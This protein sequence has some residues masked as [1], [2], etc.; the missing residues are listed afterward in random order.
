MKEHLHIL[1]H[2]IGVDKYGRGQEYRNYYA[3]GPECPAYHDCMKLCEAGLMEDNG[4]S[5]FSGGMHYFSVTRLGKK[6]VAENSEVPPKL[7]RSQKRYERWL[8]VADAVQ[9]TFG[10]WIKRGL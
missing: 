4:Q 10:E 9:M 6:F 7:T 3:V 2:S 1:Q 8:K 5:G